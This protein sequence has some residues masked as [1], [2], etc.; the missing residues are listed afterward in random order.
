METDPEARERMLDYAA[1]LN[2]AYF[3]GDFVS[4]DPQWT[5]DPAR[6]MWMKIREQDAFAAYLL[7]LPGSPENALSA[8]RLDLP[9][10]AADR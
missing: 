2:H 10:P 8:L 1:R 3:S 5:E 4:V 9:G 6:G 7:T